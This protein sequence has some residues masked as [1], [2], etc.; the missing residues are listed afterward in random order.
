MFITDRDLLALEPNL[1]RD[2]APASQR[3]V[4][5]TG[6]ISGSV[7]TLTAQDVDFAAAGVEAGCVAL[8]DGTPYEI[9]E[10]LSANTVSLSRLRSSTND[11][12]IQPSPATAKPVEVV[13]FR[14]QIAQVHAQIMRMIGIDPDDV[15]QPGRVTED[16]ITNPG[17]LRLVESLGAVYQVYTTAIGVAFSQGNPTYQR[18]RIYLDRFEHERQRT[19]AHLDLDGDGLPDA[20]RRLN[21]LQLIRA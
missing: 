17:A 14:P 9:T 20:T 12:L 15:P 19:Y 5:G 4:R 21:V 18:A 3:L 13:T 7:L 2:A 8:V 16:Q 6:S 11:P 10:R 1:F